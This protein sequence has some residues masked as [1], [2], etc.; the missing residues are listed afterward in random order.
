MKNTFDMVV[1]V[2]D[3]L[4]RVSGLINIHCLLRSR[5]QLSPFHGVLLIGLSTVSA[6][7]KRATT[8][9]L[10][11]LHRPIWF[12]ESTTKWNMMGVID[13]YNISVVQIFNALGMAVT[14]CNAH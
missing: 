12:N 4:I 5:L 1:Q 13:R 6:L 7:R 11:L 8:A 2:M 3:G 14:L 10:F 9:D